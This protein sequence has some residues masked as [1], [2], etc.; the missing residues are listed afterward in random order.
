MPNEWDADLYDPEDDVNRYQAEPDPLSEGVGHVAFANQYVLDECQEHFPESL[1]SRFSETFDR[2]YF[3]SDP[4]VLVDVLYAESGPDLKV[5][6][7]MK[8]VEFKTAWCEKH[9][10]RY[11]ALSEA[12]SMSPQKV[13]ALLHGTPQTTVA[14][15][16]PPAPRRR[17][18]AERPKATA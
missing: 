9:G 1:V 11:L 16:I 18:G 6:A 3:A 10:R 14:D 7:E 8:R 13:R 4:P 5:E 2:F 12:D 17:G 15:Q